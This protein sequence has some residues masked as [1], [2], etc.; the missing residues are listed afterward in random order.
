MVTPSTSADGPSPKN[1][2]YTGDNSKKNKSK[3]R[4]LIGG[5][6]GSSKNFNAKRNASQS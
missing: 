5:G 3:L 1:F 4:K 6:G 2:E